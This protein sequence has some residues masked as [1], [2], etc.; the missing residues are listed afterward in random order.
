MVSRRRA[1]NS[2]QTS[3]RQNT[4]DQMAYGINFIFPDFGETLREKMLIIEQG[5]VIFP[6]LTEIV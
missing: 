3:F 1:A 4:A 2:N 5:W 6:N